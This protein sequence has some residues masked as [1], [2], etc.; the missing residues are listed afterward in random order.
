M[1][2]KPARVVNGYLMFLV[3]IVVLVAGV[4][5]LIK[6]SIPA[7]AGV[8]IIIGILLLTGLFTVNPND[9]KVA[10]L[11]GNYAGSVR[12]SGFFWAN[13]FFVKRKLSLRVRNLSG[14]KLKVNDKMGNPIEIAAVIVWMFSLRR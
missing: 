13:P 12:K 8:L 7:L 1:V 3:G 14:Q 6:T 9:A 4:V 10:V 2:E 11:F 5:L